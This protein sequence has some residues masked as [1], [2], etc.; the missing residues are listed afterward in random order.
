MEDNAIIALYFARDP[1]A[2]M[3]TQEKYGAYCHAISYGILH[4]TEDAQECVNDTLLRAW[5]SIP[6]TRPR[7]FSA[8]LGRIT[9]NLSLQRWRSGH[10]QKRGGGEAALAL[11]ELEECV[12]GGGDPARD[13]EAKELQEAVGRFLAELKKSDREIFLARYWFFASM[14]EI[15]ARFG[16]SE[17]KVKTSL[18]RTRGKLRIYLEQEGLL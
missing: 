17:A 10:A 12:S 13:I 16:Y 9:R 6:P 3:Q 11:E 14:G 18:H 4:S 1:M 15:A 2:L 5:E 7:V 8:F